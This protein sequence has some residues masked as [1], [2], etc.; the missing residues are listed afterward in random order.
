MPEEHNIPVVQIE[1]KISLINDLVE[2][3]LK[4]RLKEDFGVVVSGVDI[5]AIEVDKDSDGYRRLKLVTQDVTTK[6]VQAQT[7]VNI[8]NIQD[9]QRIQSENMEE[10]LRIQREEQQY[11][12]R[13]QTQT[14][15]FAAY[16]VEAQTEVGVAGAN[17]LGHMGANNAGGMPDGGFNPVAMMA[18]MAIGGAMGQN[19]AGTMNNIM[20]GN[21]QPMQNI[22]TPPPVPQ[23]LYHVAVNGQATGPYDVATLK[24]MILAGQ[25]D[26]NTYVWTACMSDWMELGKVETL[27]GI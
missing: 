4:K 17:A 13:K 9:M 10:S 23:S 16:Q 8:K 27:K 21:S 5:S 6:T 18:G 3:N 26:A 15:N 25:I 24:Q 7:D 22:V 14:S 2:G 11:A 12:Q 1:R 19:I 20:Q